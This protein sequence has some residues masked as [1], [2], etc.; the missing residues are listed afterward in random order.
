MKELGLLLKQKREEKKVTL[1][2]VSLATK[3]G[4]RILQALEEGDLEKLPPKAFVRGFVQSYARY[5]GLD[6]KEILNR[7]QETEGTT[8]PKSIPIPQAN[9]LERELPHGLKNIITGIAIVLTIIGIIVIQ[10]IISK[11]EA[12]M[13][14]GEVQA[15]TGDDSPLLLKGT[16]SPSGS[17]TPIPL[18]ASGGV[19]VKASPVP[20]PVETPKPTPKVTAKPTPKPTEA[21]TPVP[22]PKPTPKEKVKPT[23]KPK[24][25]P[26]PQPLSTSSPIPV[27]TA[28][29][30]ATS[31][32]K[33]EALVP[34]TVII[35]AL[36]KV[37][38]K[39]TIDNKAPQEVTM[40]GDQIQTFKAKGKIKVFTPDGGAISIIQNG[41][42]LGVPGNLG[43]PKTMVFPK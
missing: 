1:E 2:E 20:P 10:R 19:E 26:V 6:V 42:D 43:Q 14:A 35:E 16:P 8:N 27:E 36:D 30:Q 5:L 21:P 7:F 25:T 9:R 12:E 39:I 34:Q 37:T 24:E 33:P 17:S 40:D 3:I 22:T 18:T 32:P 23:P 13:R 41:F 29:P 28:T 4:V 38:L 15:I 11:R 31:T